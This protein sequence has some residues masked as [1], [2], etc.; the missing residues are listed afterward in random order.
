ELHD[1]NGRFRGVARGQPLHTDGQDVA[2]PALCLALRLLFDLSDAPG[3]VVLGLVFDLLKEQ[4]LGAGRRKARRLLERAFELLP[5]VCER[6]A[7]ILELGLL[8][9]QG[10]LT[11]RERCAALLALAVQILSVGCGSSR[12]PDHDTVRAAVD[13]RSG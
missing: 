6:L 8:T 5:R 10:V 11:A 4:L 3:G 12:H 13:G 1:R 2:Y 7:F 9:S